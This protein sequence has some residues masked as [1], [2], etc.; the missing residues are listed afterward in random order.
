MKVFM[1]NL[2]Q[3]LQRVF[4]PPPKSV[5]TEFIYLHFVILPSTVTLAIILLRYL[6]IALTCVAGCSVIPA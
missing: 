3:Q 4:F 6:I 5:F 2:S 1:C